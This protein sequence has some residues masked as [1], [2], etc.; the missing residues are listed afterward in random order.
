MQFDCDLQNFTMN[1][2]YMTV[3]TIGAC[4]LSMSMILGQQPI[5]TADQSECYEMVNSPDNNA[6]WRQSGLDMNIDW[7]IKC[8]DIVAYKLLWPTTGEWSDWF[9]TGMNDLAPV[10]KTNRTRM[11]S[12]FS[13]YYHIFIIC[14]SNKYKMKRD[15]C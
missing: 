8:G 10:N 9:V 1:I 12:F 5:K 7:V 14:R 15:D 2:M 13:D 4:L 3:L 11:W 6:L